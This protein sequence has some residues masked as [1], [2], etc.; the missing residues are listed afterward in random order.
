MAV[1]DSFLISNYRWIE[2]YCKEKN[3]TEK[4]TKLDNFRQ[5]LDDFPCAFS[6]DVAGLQHTI[7]KDLGNKAWQA[8]AKGVA[9][10]K[11]IP[12]MDREEYP[13]FL[14]DPARFIE[15]TAVPRLYE[16]P[17][18]DALVREK[19]KVYYQSILEENRSFVELG[20]MGYDVRNLVLIGAPL[21]MLADFLRG[22][23]GLLTDLHS[24]PHWVMEA[25][26][27]MVE[28]TFRQVEV[29]KRYF[30]MKDVLLPL[31][32]P[33]LLGRKDYLNYYHPTYQLLLEG[34]LEGGYRVLVMVEGNVDR[35]IDLMNE[36]DHPDLL[37]HFE[38]T[39]L[40]QCVEKLKGKKT[41]FSGFYPTHL[42]RYAGMEE[43]LDAARLM[44]ETLGETDNF[45]FA[46]NKVL[47]SGD[48]TKVENVK[49]VYDFFCKKQ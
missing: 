34:L 18:N 11:S 41:R 44:K 15:K 19:A 28:L 42:L 29:Y 43:C 21:D 49:S 40:K 2:D 12:I 37:L 17:L 33:T 25:C 45:V 5:V 6:I 23:K 31:H 13:L 26:Q 1:Y 4:G 8:T 20:K 35:F 36:T 38:S 16:T 14:G 10:R 3:N 39:D 46:T 27:V 22:T 7:L 32:L 9:T 48:D 24:D 30:G 47:L